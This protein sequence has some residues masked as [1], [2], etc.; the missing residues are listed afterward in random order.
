MRQ[1]YLILMFIVAFGVA[2]SA[3]NS[4]AIFEEQI[5]DLGISTDSDV[6]GSL[7][8]VDA[9]IDGVYKIDSLTSE[10]ESSS[11][12]DGFKMFLSIIPMALKSMSLMVLPGPYLY[13]IGVPSYLA[14]AIQIMVNFVDL[15]GFIYITTGRSVN[16]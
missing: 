8:D 11:T 15:W 13:N 3:L 12:W 10:D 1:M 6:S 9:D 7:G 5:T 2:V 4:A 16:A 14:G